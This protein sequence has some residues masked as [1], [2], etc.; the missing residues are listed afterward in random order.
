MTDDLATLAADYPAVANFLNRGLP[1]DLRTLGL[2][3]R[4]NIVAG[5]SARRVVVVI[6]DAFAAASRVALTMRESSLVLHHDGGPHILRASRGSRQMNASPF[7]GALR[8][9]VRAAT[10]MLTRTEDRFNGALAAG[11]TS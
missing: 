7:L 3:S 9:A 11:S 4:I 5:K 1:A 10:D 2:S 8:G 6:T